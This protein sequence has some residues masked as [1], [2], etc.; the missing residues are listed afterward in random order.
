MFKGTLKTVKK[1]IKFKD[2]KTIHQN[3]TKNTF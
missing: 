3:I 2:T 1:S